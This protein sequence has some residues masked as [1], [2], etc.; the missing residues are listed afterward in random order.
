MITLKL[1][2]DTEETTGIPF[3]ITETRTDNVYAIVSGKT[4]SSQVANMWYRNEDGRA[5]IFDTMTVDFATGFT[6]SILLQASA[7][8]DVDYYEN[9][10]MGLR[11]VVVELVKE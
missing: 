11:H 9:L 8:T 2:L 10:G 4:T 5:N 7:L 1:K 3:T 6:L